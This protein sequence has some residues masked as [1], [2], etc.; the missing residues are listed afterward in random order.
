M[1]K[2]NISWLFKLCRH[3]VPIL[4]EKLKWAVMS[5][6][7]GYTGYINDE[8]STLI[9][10][11][12]KGKSNNHVIYLPVCTEACCIGDLSE[13]VLTDKVI[14]KWLIFLML[15]DNQIYKINTFIPFQ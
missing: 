12:L 2:L 7:A 8:I 15:S 4:M 14:L 10:K 11:T 6:L 3:A 5:H 13:N 9:R 1:Q